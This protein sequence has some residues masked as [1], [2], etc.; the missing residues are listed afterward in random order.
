MA[1]TYIVI[2]S[3]QR[4]TSMKHKHYRDPK[5]AGNTKKNKFSQENIEQHEAILEEL[6]ENIKMQEF[7]K[8]K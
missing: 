1:Y 6:H 3:N 5:T 2:P 8:K 7:N 4:Q